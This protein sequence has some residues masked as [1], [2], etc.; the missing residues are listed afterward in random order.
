MI[1]LRDCWNQDPRGVLTGTRARGEHSPQA[2]ATAGDIQEE[3]GSDKQGKALFL[4]GLLGQVPVQ[5]G[6]EL[7]TGWGQGQLERQE[8]RC[9]GEKRAVPRDALVP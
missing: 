7:E 5:A 8:Q 6:A 1:T 9:A 4:W 3:R 2:T